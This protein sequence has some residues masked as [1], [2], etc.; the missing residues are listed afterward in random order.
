[1]FYSLVCVLFS[2]FVMFVVGV[3]SN[4]LLVGGLDTG[5]FDIVLGEES[6][7]LSLFQ[8]MWHSRHNPGEALAEPFDTCPEEK[9]CNMIT[10]QKDFEQNL[11]CLGDLADSGSGMFTEV[12]CFLR[13]LPVSIWLP[14]SVSRNRPSEAREAK[15]W[16]MATPAWPGTGKSYPMVRVSL[17]HKSDGT[18]EAK[19]LGGWV[20]GCFVFFFGGGGWGNV[21]LL[22]VWCFL[23]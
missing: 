11:P 20:G 19:E 16:S 23:V 22:R 21:T 10:T 6:A 17:L 2:M 7:V 4:F 18:A 15:L 5:A 1:M 13:L 14:R 12:I 3:G 8:C 9:L